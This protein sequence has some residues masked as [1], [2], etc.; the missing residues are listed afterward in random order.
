MCWYLPKYTS[1][2]RSE[3]SVIREVGCHREQAKEDESCTDLRGLYQYV[4]GNESGDYDGSREYGEGY[5][6]SVGD[7]PFVKAAE[8]LASRL[9]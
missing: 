2:N 8:V 6:S 7:S 1:G 9:Q 4:G 3:Q 5:Q